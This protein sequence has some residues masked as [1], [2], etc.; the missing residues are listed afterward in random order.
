[1]PNMRAATAPFR[2]R[3]A[4]VAA[5]PL[6]LLLAALSLGGILTNAYAREAPS[7]VE[8]AIGQDWF[9]LAIAAPWIAICGFGARTSA[10]WR[11]LLAGAYAYAVYE[12]LIYVFAVHFNAL[13][14]LYCA[15][16]GVAAFALLA[17]IGELRDDALPADRRGAHLGG[18]FLVGIGLLFAL[19][20]LSEDLPAV[21]RNTPSQALAATGLFTNP[22][23][24]IDLSFVLPAHVVVGVLLWKRTHDG[25]L[26]GPVLLAFGVVMAASIGAMMV[27]I[28]VRGGTAPV[29]VIAA[30]FAVMAASAAVLARVLASGR[31]AGPAYLSGRRASSPTGP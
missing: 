29:P 25:E 14:L 13:F 10:R 28:A 7:W 1:M 12:L 19:L 18:G 11:V 31:A 3:F 21:M 24:A 23:H 27:V 4:I 2:A 26:Y 9:D 17:L 8:Q 20:W 22:V 30:M 6:A 15:T 5:L 16:L